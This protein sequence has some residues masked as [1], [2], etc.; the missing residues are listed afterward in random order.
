MIC[1][2]NNQTCFEGRCDCVPGYEGANCDQLSYEKYI[3]TY[4]VFERC[5]TTYSSYVSQNYSANIN[6]GFSSDL[7]ALTINNFA[8]RGF[9]VDA[10]IINPTQLIIPD[11]DY[12]A[13][14]VSGGEG[15]YQFSTQIE[16][17]YNYFVS[18]NF[19]SCTAT[20]TRF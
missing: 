8:N 2:G 16:F 20:F 14:E 15:F 19:H 1:A 4:N 6:Q 9:P 13:L 7:T 5:T 12:G 10:Y 18:N 3:G 17:N 11:R